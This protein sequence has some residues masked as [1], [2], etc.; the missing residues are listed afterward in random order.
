MYLFAGFELDQHRA[1][2][3]GLNCEPIKLRPKTFDI[4]ILFAANPGRILSKQE[5]M[6]AAWPNVHV[7]EDSLFQCIRE[8]RTALGDDRREIVKLVSGRGY[9][10]DTEVLTGPAAVQTKDQPSLFAPKI[11]VA[12]EAVAGIVSPPRLGIRF[13]GPIVAAAGLVAI[14]GLAFATPIFRPDILVKRTP[15]IAVMPM[16]EANQDP[17]TAATAAAVTDRLTDGLAKIDNIQVVTPNA[18]KASLCS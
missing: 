18:H 12:P 13:R 6:E 5:L 9:M 16:V 2:L 7:G 10:F 15:F 11:F 14:I 8:L 1:E 4:L 17:Q 3:R